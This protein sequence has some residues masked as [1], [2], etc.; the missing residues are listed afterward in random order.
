LVFLI[1]PMGRRVKFIVDLLAKI[2]KID[3][4][5]ND[6]QGIG[7]LFVCAPNKDPAAHFSHEREGNQNDTGKF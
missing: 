4:C 5:C 6:E 1:Q 7:R 3:R 2:G